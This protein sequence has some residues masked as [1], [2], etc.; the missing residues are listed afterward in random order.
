MCY[1]IRP[2]PRVG[3]LHSLF[4]VRGLHLVSDLASTPRLPLTLVL[5]PL[6]TWCTPL[7]PCLP[8]LGGE[9]TVKT[10]F[11]LPELK[12][13]RILELGGFQDPYT[14]HRGSFLYRSGEGGF[15]PGS[16]LVLG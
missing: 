15:G 14:E 9:F 1:R 4:L 8:G 11:V 13:C 16:G 7:T 12:N 6:P 3:G 10:V 2:G 5:Q